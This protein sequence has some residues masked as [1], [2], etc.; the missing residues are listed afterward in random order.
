M[1]FATSVV[2]DQLERCLLQ[3]R[4]WPALSRALRAEEARWQHLIQPN[5]GGS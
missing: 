5:L 4:T 1:G 3:L 2:V